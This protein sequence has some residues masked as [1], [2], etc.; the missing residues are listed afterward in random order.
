M[1][2]L[3]HGLLS[4]KIKLF[5]PP[6]LAPQGI[7]SGLLQK[8]PTGNLPPRTPHPGRKALEG[9]NNKPQRTPLRQPRHHQEYDFDEDEENRPPPP[10][11]PRDPEWGPTLSQLLHKWD[12]DLTRLRD[13][14]CQ[15]LEDYRKR[16]GI[17]PSRF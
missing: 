4:L 8:P 3:V 12:L 14:I 5:L 16:L 9:E 1:V 11:E 7:Y 6:L 2:L 13:T 10:Q 17:H 15:D